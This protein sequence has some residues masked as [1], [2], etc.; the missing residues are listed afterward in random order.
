MWPETALL[1]F[2]DNHPLNTIDAELVKTSLNLNFQSEHTEH[3]SVRRLTS[4]PP[5]H[6]ERAKTFLF[7]PKH[8]G[9]MLCQ[10]SEHVQIEDR[11]Y[12][13]RSDESLDLSF[14]V[15]LRY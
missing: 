4:H 11:K 9:K 10:I 8:D 1:Q 7:L 6:S 12:R 14:L 3:T 13:I 2:K 15:F 5:F